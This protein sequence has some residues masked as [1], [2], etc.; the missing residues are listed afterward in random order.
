MKLIINH[1]YVGFRPSI[2]FLEAYN[3]PYYMSIGM[4]VAREEISR[5]DKRLIEFIEKYG[6]ERASYVGEIVVEDI[7]NGTH[8]IIHDYDGYETIEYRD[9]VDWKIA[10]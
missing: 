4:P 3:I 7:P 6:S 10:E 8:Y 1:S 2:E 5:M 9:K